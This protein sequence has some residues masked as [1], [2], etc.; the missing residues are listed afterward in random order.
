MKKYKVDDEGFIIDENGNR[1][2][3]ENGN[4]MKPEDLVKSS[5]GSNDDESGSDSGNADS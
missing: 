3:D 4:P 2:L 1:V 5:D